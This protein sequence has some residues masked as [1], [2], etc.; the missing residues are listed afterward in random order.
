MEETEGTRF[1][2]WSLIFLY[3]CALA[4]LF[5]VRFLRDVI[6]RVLLGSVT[7]AILLAD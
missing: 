7:T 2:K 6:L 5:G 3:Y 1:A 4:T